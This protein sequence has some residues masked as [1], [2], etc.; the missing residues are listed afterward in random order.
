MWRA[1]ED[2][3]RS[4]PAEQLAPATIAADGTIRTASGVLALDEVQ[5]EGKRVMPAT[6]WRAGLR[7]DVRIDPT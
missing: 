6:A 5:P 1:H 7:G 4:G 2:A 3:Q